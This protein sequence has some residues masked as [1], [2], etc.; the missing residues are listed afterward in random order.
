M[1]QDA[2]DC[3]HR[4]GMKRSKLSRRGNDHLPVELRRGNGSDRGGDEVEEGSC[5]RRSM[6][7]EVMEKLRRE[8]LAGREGGFGG[9]R[10]E[11]AWSS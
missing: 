2:G 3:S 7:D 11:A 8:V 5:R 6:I 10:V 1:K 9:R 4:I